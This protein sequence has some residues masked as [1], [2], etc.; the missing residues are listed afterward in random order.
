MKGVPMDGDG[1]DS[2]AARQLSA[3][4]A[5]KGGRA[6]ASVLTPAERSEI[7]RRA[8][9]ARWMRAG[10][11]KELTAD[12]AGQDADDQQVDSGGPGPLPHSMFAGQLT[13]GDVTFECHVLSDHRRVMT[14]REVVR[15]LSGGRESGNLLRYLEGNP[16]YKSDMLNDRTVQ[17]RIP[18]QPTVANGYD[19]ELLIEICELFLDARAQGLVS[20]TRPTQK[21]VTFMAEVI[22]RASA[23]VGIIALVDE[24]TGY[25]KVRRARDLQLK[26]Q[27]FIADD[28]QEWA[29]MFP[30]DFWY[31]LA[32]LEGVKYSPRNRPLRWGKYV[33]AFVYDAIDPDIGKE[34]RK[35]NPNPRFKKNH[36]QWLQEFGRERVNNQIQQ[37]I[38][39]M[40]TC[41]D[42]DEFRKRFARVF[43]NEPEQLSFLFD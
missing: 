13:M 28:M 17:F 37:V 27:A 18:G 36:H 4:G 19:A 42:M 29:R 15:V 12:D 39:V 9:Q 23:K 7:A 11:A 22:V 3:L 5:S 8:V 31:E 26:L 32:R 25:Q 24:A 10:K 40:K 30:P 14:Q 43:K 35:I 16:L 34:L 2:S 41:D 20:K 1:D 21:K 6:R 33:M 38:A